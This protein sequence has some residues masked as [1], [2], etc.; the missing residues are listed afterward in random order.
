[1]ALP[2]GSLKIRSGL[3]Q[4]ANTVPTNPLANAIDTWEVLRIR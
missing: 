1:M 4:D 2:I 3:E